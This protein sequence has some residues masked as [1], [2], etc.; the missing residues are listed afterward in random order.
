MRVRQIKALISFMFV[1]V[2]FL[3][4]H[5]VFASKESVRSSW[6][7]GGRLLLDVDHYKA[8]H[9]NDAEKSTTEN[10]IRSARF[11]AGYKPFAFI[12]S[13]INIE[14]DDADD[15]IKLDSLSF[16]YI[17]PF[18]TVF[19]IGKQKEQ[20]GF[21]VSTSLSDITSI[22]R[23]MASTAFSAG[24]N[25]G[26]FVS[27]KTKRWYVTGSYTQFDNSDDQ[28]P[29]NKPESLSLRSSWLPI[30]IEDVKFHIGASYSYRDWKDNI[31]Q[32]R[33]SGEIHTADNII[34]SAEFLAKDINIYNFESL[35]IYRNTSLQSEFFNSS[36]VDVNGAEW[37]FSG[38]YIQAAYLLNGKRKYNPEKLNAVKPM[39][40]YGAWEFLIKY[41]YLDSR[42]H[43][44]GAI[45][46]IITSGI[47]YHYKEYRVM[48]NYLVSDIEGS[49]RHNQTEGDAFSLRFQYDI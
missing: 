44:L 23:S 12:R 11:S 30:K 17:A 42:D 19:S 34:R 18:E 31:F 38:Y 36:V 48:F 39:S 41:S 25:W 7:F 6:D 37:S 15:E 45:S 27:H 21:E 43:G 13:S 22:E 40:L 28:F 16:D 10:E 26:L 2:I 5:H 33:E 4:A 8:F 1:S 35:L 47:N 24:K 32:I 29:N 49:T 20:L 46:S 3:Y 14:Y 9:S